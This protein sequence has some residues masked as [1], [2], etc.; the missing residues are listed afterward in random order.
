LTSEHPGTGLGLSI[1]RELAKLLGGEITVVSELG[2]GSTFIVKLPIWLTH[3]PRIDIDLAG[4]GIDLTK[5]QRI[6]VSS[7]PTKLDVGNDSDDGAEPALT[8]VFDSDVS[9][10]EPS[11]SRSKS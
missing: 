3:E 7:R 1:S 4:V 2:R 6:D 9:A 5:A 8:P 10:N 11:I